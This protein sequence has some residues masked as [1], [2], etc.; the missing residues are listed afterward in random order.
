MLVYFYLDCYRPCTE[1]QLSLCYQY[2]KEC[3]ECSEGI[4]IDDSITYLEY[5][6]ISR[7]HYAY[8]KGVPQRNKVNIINKITEEEIDLTRYREVKSALEKSPEISKVYAKDGVQN[9]EYD[10]MMKNKRRIENEENF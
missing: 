10:L 2:L 5:S 1:E 7:R 4:N 6:A 9:D 3:P 8:K